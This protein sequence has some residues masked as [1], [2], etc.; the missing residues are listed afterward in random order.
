MAKP[1]ARPAARPAARQAARPAATPRQ[2]QR[3]A[4]NRAAKLNKYEEGKQ[5]LQNEL[6]RQRK[7]KEEREALGNIPSRFFLKRG[8]NT[9]VIVLDDSPSFFRYEHNYMGEGAKFKNMFVECLSE[10]EICPACK[11]L[12]DSRPYYVMILT[13]IDLTPYVNA[14]NEEIPFN[15]KL[16]AIKS[17]QQEKFQRKVDAYIKTHGTLRGAIIDI[18]RSNS[19]TSPA[20][21]DDFEF[22]DF[23][24]VDSKEAADYY[25]RAWRDK[26]GVDHVETLVDC[27]DYEEVFPTPTVEELEEMFGIEPPAGSDRSNARAGSVRNG[28]HDTQ[29]QAR[30]SPRLGSRQDTGQ[31]RGRPRP[32]SEDDV[33][34]DDKQP[35]A[36]PTG[37]AQ[38]KPA[39]RLSRSRPTRR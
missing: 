39:P 14:Q 2:G 27:V 22:V 17:N 25:V 18:Y 11:A 6:A 15:R 1:P 10:S 36:R 24:D 31:T 8:T 30:T 21:G 16:L 12:P 28:H 33:P 32:A 23:E 38:Q 3:Q 29:P 7:R 20:S 5:R 34:W 13:I 37:R 19:E 4:P 26:A 35:P 9:S